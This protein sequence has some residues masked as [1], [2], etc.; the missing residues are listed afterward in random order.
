[1]I[2]KEYCHCTVPVE[3]AGLRRAATLRAARLLGSIVRDGSA[4]LSKAAVTASKQKL[5]EKL[6]WF[7]RAEGTTGIR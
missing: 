6:N 5:R 4:K 3:K 7:T 2:A 1:M